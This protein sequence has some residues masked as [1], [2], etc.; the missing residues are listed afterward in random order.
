[1]S[2]ECRRSLPT[3][4]TCWTRCSEKLGSYSMAW[5]LEAVGRGGL[6]A[7]WP[8][9]GWSSQGQESKTS[10]S[11]ISPV[12]VFAPPIFGQAPGTGL[13]HLPGRPRRLCVS[14]E[15]ILGGRD[16]LSISFFGKP[17]MEFEYW[18]GHCLS[19]RYLITPG[20][21]FSSLQWKCL[22]NPGLLEKR[23]VAKAGSQDCGPWSWPLSPGPLR[24]SACRFSVPLHPAPA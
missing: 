18:H 15:G 14:P 12:G 6:G 11:P 3:Y 13:S 23:A 7:G 21:A 1:M 20:L 9:A 22:L 8:W 5:G 2:C 19:V 17:R 4:A 24:E 10:G 16:I